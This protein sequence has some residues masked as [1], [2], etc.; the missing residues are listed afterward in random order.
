MDSI[1][2]LNETKRRLADVYITDELRVEY[3]RHIMRGAT[4][5]QVTVDDAREFGAELIG[6]YQALA[7][8][9]KISRG[10]LN[11]IVESG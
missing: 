1:K 6:F 10:G 4:G 3:L 11:N 5:K 7:G 8:T 2:R 9:K